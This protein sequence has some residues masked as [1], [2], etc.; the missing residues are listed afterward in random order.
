MLHDMME[1]VRRGEGNGNHMIVR[2]RLPSGL[3]ILGLPTENFYSG[4]WDLGPTWNYLV[5]ADRPFLVDTG[6]TG[7]GN[8]LL[9]KLKSAGV[10][11]KDLAF[12][13]LTHGH[14]D[15][16]GG[17]SEI[18][19]A[20]RV[21]VKAHKLYDRLI[22]CYPDKAPPGVD[23][24][25]PASCW[26]CPMPASFS[27][28]H[29]R[30]YHLERSR[31]KIE[32]IGNGESS[33]M[34]AVT[35]YHLPGHSPDA[36]VFLLG[37]EVLLVGDTLLPE[38][39]PHPTRQSY[40]GQVGDVFGPAYPRGDSIYG[41]RAYLRSLKKL[42]RIGTRMDHVILLPGHRLFYNHRWNEMAV[43]ERVQEL[44]THHVERCGSILENLKQGPK[45]ARELAVVYF[46]PS[47]LKGAGI[48]M[49]ENEILSHCELL[50]ACGDVAP[51]DDGRFQATGTST[52]ELAIDALK[53]DW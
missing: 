19:Q 39:S 9:E 8:I 10:S 7:Q 15:H 11:G 41:L 40:F 23:R 26:H 2:L 42:E 25:F 24:D 49:A 48:I 30:A 12:V 27:N 44:L 52:F 6:R 53:P 38:I 21:S 22:R 33:I 17:L 34:K 16:D 51:S 14:E 43:N 45:T 18:V 50:Q 47:L 29:C 28:K 20:T 1:V 4:D 31:L 32:T 46:E 37:E 36:L 13:L 35:S 5:L 3:E